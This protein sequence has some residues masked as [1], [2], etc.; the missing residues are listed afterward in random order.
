V[1]VVSVIT[2]GWV[3]GVA[4]VLMAVPLTMII[5]LGLES[6]DDLRWIAAL[7]SGGENNGR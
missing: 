2:W 3:W 4:G 1:V 6:S 7:M 5:K